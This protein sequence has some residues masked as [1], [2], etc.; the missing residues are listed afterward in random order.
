MVKDAASERY[1]FTQLSNITRKIYS[2]EDD[3][4]LD[5]INYDGTIAEPTHYL[6][7]IPMTLING[8][9]GIGTGFAY[10]GLCHDPLA[11]IQYVKNKLKKK[12]DFNENVP[13]EP[14]YEGI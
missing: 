1:I 6:P 12:N 14:Y 4:L 11:V 3:P 8:G 9:K 13:I 5:Y 7:I 10:E 2:I